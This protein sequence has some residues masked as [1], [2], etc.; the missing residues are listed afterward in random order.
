MGEGISSA[1]TLITELAS[2]GGRLFL[3]EEPETDLHPQALRLLLDLIV[4]ATPENQFIVSTHS[5]LVLR[6]L[7]AVPN[8]AIF[9]TELVPANEIPTTRFAPV[10]DHVERLDALA[11][12]GYH[13]AV[14]PGWLV[15]E[16]SSAEQVVTQVL[17][18]LF[19]PALGALKTVAGRGA[20]AVPA[21]VEDLRRVVLF[22]HLSDGEVPRAWVILD[23]DV[24]GRTASEKL[25]ARFPQWPAS[26]F[27]VLSRPT[28]ES[29]YP[30]RFLGDIEAIEEVDDSRLRSV[31][32]GAL[33]ARVVDWATREPEAAR[34]ELEV[35]A[36]D[37]I[38][39]L[40]EIEQEFRQ[41]P[42]PVLV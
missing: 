35:S 41:L 10:R 33:A 16:E 5:D 23:D 17:A 29:Y 19:V 6:H 30:E 11:E 27:R 22:S 26:R 12:L 3:I 31:A 25:R 13:L 7:G 9:R 37:V 15:F 2:S 8:T 36:A 28:F 14:A 34:A 20:G 32:K 21:T 24:A 18:P 40:R 1:L 4:D 38:D 39:T 42:V